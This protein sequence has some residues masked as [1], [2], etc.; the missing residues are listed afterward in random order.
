MTNSE[1]STIPAA[2][3]TDPGG[4]GHLRWWDGTAW[5]AHLAPQPEPNPVVPTP[6]AQTPVAQPPITQPPVIQAPVFVPVEESQ[7][8]LTAEGQPYVPF[9]T[10][11]NANAQGGYG[12]AEE[13]ARPAQWNTPGSW[14]LAFSQLIVLVA[15]VLFIVFDSSAIAA[16]RGSAVPNGPLL[17]ASFA[18]EVGLL[19]LQLLFA[20]MDRRKLRSLG[21]LQTASIWWV[22][23]VPPLIYLIMRGVAVSRE[24][25]RGFG[26]LIAYVAVYAGIIVLSI[27]AAVA[28]PLFLHTTVGAT[29]STEFASSLQTGLDEKG[30]H[31]SVTC[32]PTIPTAIGATFS[33][34]ATDA[35]GSAHVLAIQVV[36]GSDGKPTV[37]LQSVSPPISG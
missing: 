36:R 16:A 23:L 31:F 12:A 15:V 26:P 4:S 18:V 17:Y 6:V 28:I 11:W 37:K 22:L 35:A 30:G 3:Y 2:W 10:A 1:G 19:A 32:P 7:A 33:C 24:V 8:T 5:T 9:Q 34:T 21:Y 14:L 13:F 27:I 29:S 25:R 20:A